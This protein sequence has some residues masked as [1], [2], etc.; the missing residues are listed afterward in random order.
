M[1]LHKQHF[2]FSKQDEILKSGS[3]KLFTEA[4]AINR[5]RLMLL[6]EQK[7]CCKSNVNCI[8]FVTPDRRPRRASFMYTINLF[9]K[10]RKS[11]FNANCKF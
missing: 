6:I 8:D 9:F 5:E 10:S 4:I 7:L 3:K 1:V 11:C 2:V